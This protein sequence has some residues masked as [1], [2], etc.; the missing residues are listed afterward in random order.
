[1]VSS[2]QRP[3][4][5]AR[6]SSLRLDTFCQ[7]CYHIASFCPENGSSTAEKPTLSSSISSVFW[8]KDTHFVSRALA[9]SLHFAVT[10]LAPLYGSSA[11]PPWSELPYCCEVLGHD[12]RRSYQCLVIF[13]PSWQNSSQ[14]PGQ[15]A[16]SS[17]LHH[18][19]PPGIL[20][21]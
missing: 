2:F 7:T 3:F 20:A 6:P 5:S 11:G 17:Y 21:Y 10:F 8:Y 16:H 1:M 4:C 18:Y 14:C 15:G 19:R 12:L 13:Q 9:D